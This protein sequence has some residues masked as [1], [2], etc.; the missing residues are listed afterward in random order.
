MHKCCR[1]EHMGKFLQALCC[2]FPAHMA[3]HSRAKANHASKPTNASDC[4]TVS[5][6]GSKKEQKSQE[7]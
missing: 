2:V 4:Q 6:V 7:Y 1:M 3:C 5:P